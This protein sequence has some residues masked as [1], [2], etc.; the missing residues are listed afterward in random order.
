MS[1]RVCVGVILGAHGLKGAVRIKSFTERAVDVAAYGAVEDEAGGRRFRLRLL[2]EVKGAVTARIEGIDERNAAE[3][4][5]GLKLYVAKSSLPP[6]EEE[7]FYY[8][9]LVGLKAELADGKAMGKVKGV[10]DFGGGDVIEIAGPDGT[11]MLP[12]TKAAVPVVDIAGGR[13]V[14]EPPIEIEAGPG[15]VPEDEEEEVGGN[16]GE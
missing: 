14:V 2:G 11:V 16:D 3:A 10:F 13:L 6:P 15:D 12:F 1:E 4:L 8:S 7:E 9:D 5:K